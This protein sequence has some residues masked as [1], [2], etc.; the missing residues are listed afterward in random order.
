M[1]DVFI[2][3]ISCISASRQL[4]VPYTV[5]KTTTLPYQS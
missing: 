5:G 3:I 1:H 2:V 4:G